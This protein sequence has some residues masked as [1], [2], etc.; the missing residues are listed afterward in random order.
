MYTRTGNHR[1]FVA[2]SGQ[3]RQAYMTHEENVEAGSAI[4]FHM[5]GF[6]EFEIRRQI[7]GHHRT[8]TGSRI[9]VWRRC[10]VFDSARTDVDDKQQCGR[11]ATPTAI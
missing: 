9:L 4:Y 2:Q 5:N 10:R 1:K 11:T 3:T 8:G 7:V 6:T